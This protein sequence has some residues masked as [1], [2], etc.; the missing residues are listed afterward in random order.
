MISLEQQ[1]LSSVCFLKNWDKTGDIY[2][3]W[4]VERKKKRRWTFIGLHQ[5]IIKL[6]HIWAWMNGPRG[7][8]NT[9]KVNG[10]LTWQH[11]ARQSWHLNACPGCQTKKHW[12]LPLMVDV[13]RLSSLSLALCSLDLLRTGLRN[14]NIYMLTRDYILEITAAWTIEDSDI[15]Y[16]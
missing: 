8:R 10:P 11:L 6:L 9:R 4:G 5:P 13:T 2:L 12:L 16:N 1:T 7:S 15:S 14:T 3:A